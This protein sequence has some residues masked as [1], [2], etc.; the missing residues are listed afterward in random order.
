MQRAFGMLEVVLVF[1]LIGI[2]IAFAK[3][4]ASSQVYKTMHYLYTNLLYAKNLALTQSTTYTT[5][6]QTRWL[7]ESFPSIH[8]PT[9]L[10]D[11]TLWQMQ[12]HLSGKYTQSSFSIYLDTPRVAQTTHYD[13][14][15]MAGDIIAV[16][17]INMR[18]LSGYNNTNTADFC[19]N[20]TET[21]VRF[22]ESYGV[23]ISIKAQKSC[24]ESQTSRIFFDYQGKPYCGKGKIPLSEPYI[25][26]F[27]KQ[28]A[29]ARLCILPH[30]GAILKGQAC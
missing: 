20:N 8:A 3:P 24:K 16:S 12:F 29:R 5:L 19:K 26:T 18:C 1:V 2:L 10:S 7:S 27:A 9:L 21:S 25:I 28:K 15:P 13:N 17:G 22:L 4:S 11:P 30:T 14:R 6:P 23:K